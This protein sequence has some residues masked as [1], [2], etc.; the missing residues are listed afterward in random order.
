[1]YIRFAVTQRDHDTGYPMGVFMAANELRDSIDAD[2]D[3]VARLHEHRRWFN[4]NLPAPADYG[5]KVEPRSIFWFK[6][7]ASECIRRIWTLAALLHEGGY[8]VRRITCTR[9]GRI[10]FEDDHQIAAIPFR[11]TRARL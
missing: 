8:F 3:L 7:D 2:P 10:V 4:A 11:D 9:P 6:P 1:M 5:G